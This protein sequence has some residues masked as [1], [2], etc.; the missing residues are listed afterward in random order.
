MP[1]AVQSQDTYMKFSAKS[2]SCPSRCTLKIQINYRNWLWPIHLQRTKS[3]NVK[4]ACQSQI[5]QNWVKNDWMKNQP[6]IT[7]K[8]EQ[9]S[10]CLIN[11]RRGITFWSHYWYILYMLDWSPALR[12]VSYLCGFGT[13]RPLAPEE[14]QRAFIY[15]DDSA[16]VKSSLL[17]A[18]LRFWSIVL[19]QKRIYNK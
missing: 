15:W 7:Q 3:N 11:R 14:R 12:S 13:R 6:Y 17:F 4:S 1:V 18:V 5:L 2:C 19:L 10:G 8:A 16:P 9:I